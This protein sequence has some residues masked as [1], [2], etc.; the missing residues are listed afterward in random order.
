MDVFTRRKANV[1]GSRLVIRDNLR[2]VL[3]AIIAIAASGVAWLLV[4]SSHYIAAMVAAA[5]ACLLVLAARASLGG[6][7]IDEAGGLVEIPGGGVSANELWQWVSPRFVL[8]IAFRYRIALDDIRNI[9][10]ISRR[11]QRGKSSG[12]EHY[13]TLQGTFGAASV[14]FYDEGKRDQAFAMLREACGVGVPVTRS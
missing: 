4:A 5:T 13:L 8:Q 12:R 9:R 2:I 7:V 10:R 11:E 6:V 14:R 1:A 3:Q